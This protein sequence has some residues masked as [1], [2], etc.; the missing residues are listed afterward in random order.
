MNEEKEITKILMELGTPCHLAGYDLI[1]QAV[2]IML[3]NEKIKQTDIYRQLAENVGKTQSQVERNIR[4]AIEVTFYNIRPEMAK[5]TLATVLVT[6]EL[7]RAT[8]SSSLQSRN[9]RRTKSYTQ[10]RG[11][12]ND[13]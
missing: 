13:Y 5:N 3:N 2:V 7:S 10:N 11:I 4:H 12:D 6:T 8:R 9:T 1:R